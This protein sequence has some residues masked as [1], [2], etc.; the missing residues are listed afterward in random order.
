MLGLYAREKLGGQM[1]DEWPHSFA[2][3][4][5][6][7]QRHRVKYVGTMNRRFQLHIRIVFD[8]RIMI[9]Y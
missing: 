1:M 8:N 3:L 4:L 9:D 6:P 2:G 5:P 7:L